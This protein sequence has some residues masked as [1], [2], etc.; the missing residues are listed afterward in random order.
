V[1]PVVLL[2]RGR[3]GAVVADALVQEGIAFVE[4]GAQDLRALGDGAF[5]AARVL[6]LPA[7]LDGPGLAHL[8]RWRARGGATVLLGSG[9]P[10][11]TV[12]DLLGVRELPQVASGG[13]L[14]A[15]SA[16]LSLP[17]TAPGRPLQVTGERRLYAA[18][19]DGVE[20][21]ALGSTN[22]SAVV[23]LD[24]NRDGFIDE[25]WY[26]CGPDIV[27]L[28]RGRTSVSA[29]PHQA[30]RVFS[31]SAAAA[32]DFTGD[33]FAD[34][35]L[36][37]SGDT[38]AILRGG[39]WEP[40]RRAP[41]RIRH[42]LCHPG[43]SGVWTIHLFVGDGSVFH[44]SQDGGRSFGPPSV[45]APGGVPT[46]SDFS[47]SFDFVDSQGSRRTGSHVWSGG[48]FFTDLG[49]GFESV[50]SAFDLGPTYMHANAVRPGLGF[51][52]DEDRRGLRDRLTLIVGD[53]LH[54][55]DPATG[56]FDYPRAL[57]DMVVLPKA[58]LVV[59]RGSTIGFL[60]DFEGTVQL[61]QQGRA[62][63]GAWNIP[64]HGPRPAAVPDAA[65]A[66]PP[67]I[68]SFDDWVDY[69]ASDLPQADL[70]ERLLR[71]AIV[72]LLSVPL[73]RV[74]YWPGGAR[75]VASM[76][77]DVESAQ[78]GDA[79]LVRSCTMELGRRVAAEGR[80]STFFLLVAPE[81]SS[82][83]Q[84]DVAELAALG[85]CVTLHFNAFVPGGVS[86]SN[87]RIQADRLRALGVSKVTGN[88]MHG[89]AW[90]GSRVPR[91]LAAEPEIFFDS[92]LGGGPGFSHCGSVLP[93]RI[94][95]GFGEPFSSFEE[96]GHGLMDVADAT[97]YFDGLAPPG[98]LVMSMDEL[99]DRARRLALT[100]DEA[101]YGVLD[102]SFHPVVVAGGVPPI[103]P[104][105]DAVADHAAFLS[106]AGIAS[107]SLEE[108]AAWWRLR[109]G[110]RIVDVTTPGVGR[111]DFA[112]EAE[113]EVASASILVPTEWAGQR[114]VE[115]SAAGK[116]L[117][118]SPHL[119]DGAQAALVVL[120]A[121][122]GRTE[123]S[124]R[125]EP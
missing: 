102:C 45:F 22:P 25:E 44:T 24:A 107:M 73:P 65:P 23:T 104:F 31:V 28:S 79:E 40:P 114:L 91:A 105:V 88:R 26:F 112:L 60:F 30:L 32:G 82:L 16:E 99:L 52:S 125:Y 72:S 83:Q 110:L 120:D 6:V 100:N 48:V 10:E 95:D 106:K 67:I 38:F 50:P 29:L 81:T 36:V 19:V 74:W 94:Y 2:R 8:E 70:H 69:T 49:L 92:S 42:V 59:R 86:R 103:P 85:H 84:A 5:P 54:R 34:D 21:L 35:L 113:L 56:T 121:A 117:V 61:L 108:V 118:W 55:L 80:R 90:P 46:P 47:Y 39:A 12:K 109:R 89:L 93:F 124:A 66:A 4:I 57:H 71:Q 15:S 63:G 101:L 111:V 64:R 20:A 51:C 68:S 116:E 1:P 3:L 87:L 27:K 33:G 43:P 97:F 77:H 53:N 119:L 58:P 13:H 9:W 11:G 98:G 122:A 123:L 41:A 115:V 18:E 78:P 14:W 37:A 75:S 62:D 17:A 96:I 76:S 7:P